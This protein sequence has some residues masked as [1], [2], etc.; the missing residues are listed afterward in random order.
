[1][2]YFSCSKSIVFSFSWTN[3]II[4]WTK[5]KKR[6]SKSCTNFCLN[7]L[8]C[9]NLFQMLIWRVYIFVRYDSSYFPTYLASKFDTNLLQY[10]IDIVN[11]KIDLTYV[12]ILHN[13]DKSW[14]LYCEVVSSVL[15]AY[16]VT[17][18]QSWFP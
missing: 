9:Q 7:S 1:M 3:L 13:I 15:N 8:M 17:I 14:F 16:F 18:G 2:N 11:L 12:T 10:F 6:K 4:L 5:T